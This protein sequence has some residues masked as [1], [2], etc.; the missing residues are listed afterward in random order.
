MTLKGKWQIFKNWGEHIPEEFL[1]VTHSVYVYSYRYYVKLFC[2]N[3]VVRDIQ[4]TMYVKVLVFLQ[5]VLYATED[6]LKIWQRQAAYMSLKAHGLKRTIYELS[7]VSQFVYGYM[8]I[9]MIHNKIQYHKISAF[10][11]SQATGIVSMFCCEC[12][13]E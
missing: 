10:F 12:F 13:I 7:V 1:S 6:T 2:F 4:M 9:L 11:G 3:F 8:Q 5:V